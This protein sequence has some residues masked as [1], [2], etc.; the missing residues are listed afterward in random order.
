[1]R[2]EG[3]TSLA[4]LTRFTVGSLNL[5]PHEGKFSYRTKGIEQVEYSAHLLDEGWSGMVGV[6]FSIWGREP[7]ACYYLPCEGNCTP[8][9]FSL[10][11]CLSLELQ[12]RLADNE[13]ASRH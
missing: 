10:A 4:L 12:L 9:A 3:A 1:M 6:S 2:P 13:K 11:R 7:D 5:D 8:Y